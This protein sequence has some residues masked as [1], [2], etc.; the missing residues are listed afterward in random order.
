MSIELRTEMGR[1]CFWGSLDEFGGMVL[2][3]PDVEISEITNRSIARK[4]R[5]F[6]R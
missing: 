6:A 1:F 4:R 3:A 5:I 2:D